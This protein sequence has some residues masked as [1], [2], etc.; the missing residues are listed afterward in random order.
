LKPMAMNRHG[1]CEEHFQNYYVKG[2]A[3]SKV[4]APDAKPAAKPDEKA[5]AS[6]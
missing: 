5:A 2:I 3:V 1:Y 6:A 4:A